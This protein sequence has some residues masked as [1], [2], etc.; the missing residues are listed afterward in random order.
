MYCKTLV[1][2]TYF[3]TAGS[4]PPP[5]EAGETIYTSSAVNYEPG[6]PL[7]GYCKSTEQSHAPWAF[8]YYDGG[9]QSCLYMLYL[10]PLSY[11]VEVNS[12]CYVSEW[13]AAPVGA[14]CTANC[15]A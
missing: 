2:A 3:C 13:D 8:V 15:P 1:A 4:G 11:C 14:E 7:P 9:S 12:T 5:H 10:S 6:D